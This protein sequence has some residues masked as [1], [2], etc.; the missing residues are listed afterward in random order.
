MKSY[1]L[2]D[3]NEGTYVIV[4]A[5]TPEAAVEKL[6]QRMWGDLSPEEKAA[7]IRY[8]NEQSEKYRQ[9]SME[10]DERQRVRYAQQLSKW[11][12]APAEIRECLPAPQPPKITSPELLEPIVF[13][14]ADLE[15]EFRGYISFE[16]EITED[17]FVLEV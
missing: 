8:R 7:E 15:A 13:T 11:Y 5:E 2:S 4:R 3:Q 14:E 1:L 10:H 17:V 16:R 6:Y 12:D 9:W